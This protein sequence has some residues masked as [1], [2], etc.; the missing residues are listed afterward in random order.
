[1][2]VGPFA[3]LV[4]AGILPGQRRRCSRSQS[5][6]T[7]HYTQDRQRRVTGLRS[8]HDRRRR[9]R[10]LL[11]L[12]P[13]VIAP[14]IAVALDSCRLATSSHDV[15]PGRRHDTGHAFLPPRQRHHAVITGHG[16]RRTSSA[17]RAD[18]PRWIVCALVRL[19]SL[20]LVAG[21]WSA[22]YD[23]ATNT[24]GPFGSGWP[25]GHRRT[26]RQ[27]HHAGSDKP[28]PVGTFQG[29]GATEAPAVPSCTSARSSTARS[30][31]TSASSRRRG[32]CRPRTLLDQRGP[33]EQAMIGSPYSLAGASYHQPGGWY[34]HDPG[35]RRGP[36]YCPVL[37]SVHRLRDPLTTRR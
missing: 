22:T 31:S 37:R 6:A 12:D 11:R 4:V 30:P 23:K 28:I 33:I 7:V 21:A 3:R 19:E 36:A 25:A 16:R 34:I 10:H 20:V 1:M 8:A 9:R 15:R 24:F 18:C 13:R 2:E 32:T 14:D 35:W 27:S 5:R 29:W 26:P 17:S